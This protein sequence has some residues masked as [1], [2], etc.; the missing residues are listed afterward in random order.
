MV[1]QRQ[2]FT[3]P[4]VYSP[5]TWTPKWRNVSTRSFSCHVFETT[6]ASTNV[7]TFT[8]TCHFA[9]LYSSQLHSSKASCCLCASRGIARYERR[10]LW[11]VFWPRTQ[12]PCFIRPQP[13]SKL[14]KWSTPAPTRF[15]FAFS[16]TKSMRYLIESLTPLLTISCSK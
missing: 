6:S 8:F 11:A 16:W 1:G 9:R 4:P 12:Y 7:S 14:P 13:C 15:S 10:L 2:L 3:K 5:R